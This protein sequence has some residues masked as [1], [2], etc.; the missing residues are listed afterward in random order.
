MTGSCWAMK[1][2]FCGLMTGLWSREGQMRQGLRHAD[3]RKHCELEGG[4]L[5]AN[6]Q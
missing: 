6:V 5:T 2:L 1:K 4:W 3:R